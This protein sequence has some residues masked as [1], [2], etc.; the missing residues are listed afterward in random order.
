[1]K[2]ILLTIAVLIFTVSCLIGKPTPMPESDY[3]SRMKLLDATASQI[4]RNASRLVET[5]ALDDATLIIGLQQEADRMKGVYDTAVSLTPP[6]KYT[7]AHS[8]F[9]EGVRLYRDGLYAAVE[10]T[11]SKA[12]DKIREVGELMEAGDEKMRQVTEKLKDMFGEKRYQ[13]V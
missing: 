3:I 6:P 7:E 13:G 11:E 4:L 9:V 10:A 12:P 1:M 8:L 2:K 5:S